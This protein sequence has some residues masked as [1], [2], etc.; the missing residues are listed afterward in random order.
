MKSASSRDVIRLLMQDGWI[1]AATDGRHVQFKHPIKPGRVTVAHPVKDIPV[2]TLRSI[3]RQ[4]G[5]D[6]GKR[7]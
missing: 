7:R 1:R 4:A 6:W 2:G 5:W 3:Y